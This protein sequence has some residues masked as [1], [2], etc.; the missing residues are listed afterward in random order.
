LGSRQLTPVVEVRP[1][2]TADAALLLTWANDSDTRAASFHPARIETEAHV[3][4]LAETL[5]LPTRRLFI[6][7]LDGQPIGQVRLDLT[8]SGQAEVGISVAPERRG[9]GLGS[10]LLAAGLEAG[11]RDRA[12][13]VERF[14]AR[15][16]VGNEASMR[17]FE[18]A[19]FALRETGTCEGMPCLVYESGA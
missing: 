10:R 9:Q 15:V 7:L 13:G 17:L 14:V 11:R 6:G 1:A 2:T 16:R 4:W 19:G 8:G 3:T 12:F 18:R 5:T